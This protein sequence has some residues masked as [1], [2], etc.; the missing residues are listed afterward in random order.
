M[1]VTSWQI[2]FKSLVIGILVTA[3]A[4]LSFAGTSSHAQRS[5]LLG[6]Y[7]IAPASDGGVFRLNTNNGMLQYF[8][9]QCKGSS[10]CGPTA[11][12]N[13]QNVHDPRRLTP[14]SGTR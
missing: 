6:Q 10:F 7:Q 11:A 1:K 4:L 9:P 3:I 13:E 5:V 12:Q 8:G 2:D 14:E